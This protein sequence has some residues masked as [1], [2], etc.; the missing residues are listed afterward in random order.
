MA[1][2]NATQIITFLFVW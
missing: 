2:R 1:V